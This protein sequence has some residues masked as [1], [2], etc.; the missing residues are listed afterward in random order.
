MY[1]VWDLKNID[2]VV[3]MYALGVW[4]GKISIVSYKCMYYAYDFKNNDSFVQ[5][6]I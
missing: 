6:Y 2:S 4:S 5:M 1:S 3:Q